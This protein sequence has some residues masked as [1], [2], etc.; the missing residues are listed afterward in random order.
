MID[1]G[2]TNHMTG[3][4]RMFTSYEEDK[5]NDDSIT[6]GDGSQGKILGFCK[7]AITPE[8]SISKVMLV[9]HLDYNLLSVSQ[10]FDMVY[11]CL[12]TNV[13]VTV[14]RRSDDSIAFK[15]VLKGKL[16]I[17]DFTTDKAELD[18][19]L[20]VKAN[21][22]WLWHRRLAHVGMRN[23]SKLLKGGHILG[24]TNVVF[25]KDRPCGACQ[26]GKQVGA[27]HPAKNIMTTTRPL[28]LLHMDLFGPIAYISIGGNKYGLVIVDDF[29]RFTWVFFLHDKGETHGV[30]KK[31]L[32]RAQNEFNLRIK[33]IR[34][35]N[36]SEFKNTNVEEYLD[37]EGIKHEFSAPYSPQQNGVAERK[38][39]TLIEMARAMLDEYKT[40]D[41]FWAEAI[42]TACHATN[43]LYLHRLLKKTPYELLTGNKPNVS[44][45]R[46]FG[47]KCFILNKKPKSSK[48][49]PKTS[50]GFLLGYDSNTR[51]YRVFN[52]DSGCVEVTCDVVFDET[53][54]SQVEQVDLDELDD[55]QAPN[56]AL[57]NMAIGDIRPQEPSEQEK[58]SPP[59]QD[60]NEDQ[61]QNQDQDQNE[62]QGGIND[63]GG[64]EGDDQEED[65]ESRPMVPH[66]RVHQSIQR[67]HPV[68]NILG[69]IEKGVTTRSRVAT[70]CE[71]YSSVFSLEPLRVEDALNDPDWV[72]AMQE[73]LNNFKRNE[74][75]T[76]VERPKQNVVGTKWVF[77]NKQDEHGV[78]TR[79]KARLVAKGYSQVEGLDF[80][81]TYAPVARLESIRILL[82]YATNHDIKLYQ[83]DVKSAFLN[84][85]IKEEVYV[86]QPPGFEDEEYP[87]HVYKLNKALYGLKQAPRAWYECLRD[88]LISNGFKIG[89][90][91]STLFTKRM[92]EDIFM[93]PY[94]CDNIIFGS[95][96]KSFCDEFSKI[97][98]KK[99]E[100]S[101]MGE[102]TFFL[103]FQVK[104]L[105]EGTFISQTKYTQDIL[106]KFDMAN[107][108]PRL[109]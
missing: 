2:C 94:I 24:L 17:V 52:K 11:N 13:G 92:E 29:T 104:Q 88:F 45:F 74:V 97:M 71:H 40:S 30:L 47:S 36:G 72:K 84:G 22:G 56:E 32:R 55:E 79:N 9:D 66:P 46:V 95:T 98:T 48:F 73:E 86:E 96:N 27:P 108:K 81:E 6:F 61:E 101:M 5:E 102:L 60:Q 43:R 4:K 33:N 3:E 35:D 87:S 76:L 14:F 57:R 12:F 93:L 38:N 69:D 63:Q 78:V 44:Y 106:K 39:R 7:I 64:D 80:G 15:G 18:T 85:P 90:A 49:S 109:P 16:Y 100:M 37:E 68:D 107:A 70:F 77:R 42:N 34:S 58:T 54:G 67:D 1:S 8:H 31:F 23:L 83:M 10:L 21:M 99:F 82:A 89:K 41:R 65:E 28:E 51:A 62:D 50:E 59:D 105:E 91:D 26:A 75:W 20:I 103:G 53:N 25:E 19:C